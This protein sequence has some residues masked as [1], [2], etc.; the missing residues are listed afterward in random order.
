MRAFIAWIGTFLVVM[1]IVGVALG[2]KMGDLLF[3]ALIG[4]AVASGVVRAATKAGNAGQN[5]PSAN[6]SN[7]SA[8]VVN[9][10]AAQPAATPESTSAQSDVV[11][12]ATCGSSNATWRWECEKCHARLARPAQQTTA[13]SRDRPGCVTAY[14]ILV[15][16]GSGIIG[17]GG[18]AVGVAQLSQPGNA[19]AGLATITIAVTVGVLCGLFTRGIWHLKNWARIVVI[20][21]QGIACAAYLLSACASLASSSRTTSGPAL[22]SA[23]VGLAISG[24]IIYWFVSHGEYFY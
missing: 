20:V 7:A 4:T 14:A 21:L 11:Y 23:L 16:I 24:V 17:L 3:G 2:G 12:C 1:M 5:N 13:L 15:G 19:G 18:L 10:I 6:W 8:P 22:L 9:H